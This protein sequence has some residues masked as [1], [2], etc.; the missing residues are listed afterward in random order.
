M[1]VDRGLLVISRR[2]REAAMMRKIWRVSVALALMGTASIALG[3]QS[4]AAGGLGEPREGG[5]APSIRALP[6]PAGMIN[7]DV[8]AA[9]G[10]RA[11]GFV[12]NSGGF[13]HV[14]V[15]THTEHGW[16]VRDLGD[17]GVTTPFE[18]LSATGLD[19]R[20]DVA[21]GVSSDLFEG[22]LVTPSGIHR[23]RDFGGGTSA[24][25]RAINVHGV[26]VGEALDAAGN[27]FAAMWRHWWSRPVR[28]LPAPGYDGSYAQG[29]NDRGEV[30]GGSFSFGSL[31]TLAMRWSAQGR[32][33]ALH[34]TGDA[35]AMSL[36]DLGTVVGRALSDPRTAL[37]WRRHRAPKRLGMFPDATS[38]RA[39][40]ANDRGE[41]VGFEGDD[42]PGQI[43]VRHLLFWPG[44]G[45]AK[46]LLPLSGSWADGALSHVITPG[47][48]VFGS[49]A[50]TH[51]SL[52]VPTVWRCA[53][54]QAFVPSAR[55]VPTGYVPPPVFGRG[56][57]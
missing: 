45:P 32:G 23:L 52:P 22:W 16:D 19:A 4:I 11:A 26:M 57:R 37:V 46:S 34:A 39:L 51:T 18:P 15:W 41:V 5:C 20:G 3:G 10:N 29:V 54:A 56:T 12:G 49:S 24:Y 1:S 8:L 43:P 28:L 36:N 35:E 55:G 21:V 2:H 27:D 40:A 7:G 33:K 17:F 47:G 53:S 48:T 9:R 6:L 14:A 50:V 30:A 25:V 38:A 44:E 42:P 13:Q 31:P